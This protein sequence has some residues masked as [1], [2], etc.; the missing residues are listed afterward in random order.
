M[1]LSKCIVAISR[2]TLRWMCDYKSLIMLRSKILS[3]ICAK[4]RTVAASNNRVHMPWSLCYCLFAPHICMV[5]FF[6]HIPFVVNHTINTT[7]RERLQQPR[8]GCAWR[9][10]PIYSYVAPTS[11][12]RVISSG[13]L[14]CCLLPQCEALHTCRS[15][16]L[17]ATKWCCDHDGKV[18]PD[19]AFTKRTCNR[20]CCNLSVEVALNVRISMNGMCT[21]DKSH[22]YVAQTS[23]DGMTSSGDLCCC[24]L[25]QCEALRTCC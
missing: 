22:I 12:N 9:I 10:T 21:K 24:L 5:L 25:P 13:D 6:T 16:F 23:K 1:H 15:G 11:N 7:P 20:C 14:H 3:G 4:L 2:L 19:A 8:T 17:I 18:M